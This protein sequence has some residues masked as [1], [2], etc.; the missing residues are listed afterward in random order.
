MNLAII[1]SKILTWIELDSK[2]ENWKK[3]GKKI[4]FTNGCFDILHLGHIEY[5]SKAKDLGDILIVGLNSDSSI[6]KIK[7]EHRPINN[8]EARSILLSAISFI[9]A[10]TIFTDD[11]PYYLIKMVKP[12][13]LVK[14][15]DYKEEEIVGYDIVKS[16]G[17]EVKVIE[18]TEGYSSTKIIEKL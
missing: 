8:Q 3:E 10:I 12:N 9:D 18:I 11:N 1:K 16:Y 13:I 7:G 17:G 15:K 4:I 5:L 2:I 6:K 14:G